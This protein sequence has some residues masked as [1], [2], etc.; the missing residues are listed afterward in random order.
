MK[1]AAD[2]PQ[3]PSPTPLPEWLTIEDVC[4]LL[5]VP[6]WWVYQRTRT[7][8]IP[9]YKLGKYLRFRLDEINAWVAIHRLS[10]EGSPNMEPHRTS[11]AG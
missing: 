6:K 3:S 11:D 4:Q 10:A 2:S 9:H 5:R 7:R 1:H 8:R